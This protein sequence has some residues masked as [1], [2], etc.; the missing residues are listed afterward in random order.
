[1][2]RLFTSPFVPS[3]CHSATLLS[4]YI[5]LSV[6]NNA[7]IC[8]YPSLFDLFISNLSIF[9]Y[10]WHINM[11]V[12]FEREKMPV[13]HLVWLHRCLLCVSADLVCL[14]AYTAVCVS[15]DVRLYASIDLIC[16][17]SDRSFYLPRDYLSV[18]LGLGETRDKSHTIRHRSGGTPWT[19]I[20]LYVLVNIYLSFYLYLYR[21]IDRERMVVWGVWV[22]CVC[23]A[24]DGTP[25][26]G[27]LVSDCER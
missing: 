23:L 9:I 4:V 3:H 7:S 2:S 8:P 25:I 5:N 22:C 26:G 16:R 1:M 15:L 21:S 20:L 19:K 24:D 13:S 6:Y 12:L 10:L 14:S 17:S 18:R 27:R 11:D